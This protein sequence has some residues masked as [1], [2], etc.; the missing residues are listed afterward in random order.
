MIAL[1]TSAVVCIALRE[2]EAAAF[3]EIIATQDCVIGAPTLL[4]THLVLRS[5]LSANVSVLIEALLG[6]PNVELVPFDAR[7]QE[8]ARISFDRFGKGRGH[9]AQLNLGDCMAY[10]VAKAAGIPLLFKGDDFAATDIEP[11]RL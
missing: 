9:P 10:A 6:R 7:H 2:P 11:V 4:E 3:A 8:L 1:D 5:R